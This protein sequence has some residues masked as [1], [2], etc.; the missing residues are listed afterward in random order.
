MYIDI[1][2]SDFI[3]YPETGM[4]AASETCFKPVV[5]IW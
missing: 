2:E 3:Q 5:F 1:R 4:L